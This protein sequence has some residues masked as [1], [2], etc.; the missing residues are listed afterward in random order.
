M[1]FIKENRSYLNSYLDK[2][3]LEVSGNP[4]KDLKIPGYHYKNSFQ[5]VLQKALLAWIQL[6]G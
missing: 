4:Y 5:I 2:Y 6:P 3:K 1:Y